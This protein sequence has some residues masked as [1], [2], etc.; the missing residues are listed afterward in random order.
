MK[1]MYCLYSG[2][3]F[4]KSILIWFRNM[5]ICKPHVANA[6]CQRRAVLPPLQVLAKQK[7]GSCVWGP[8]IEGPTQVR[9]ASDWKCEGHGHGCLPGPAESAWKECQRSHRK[10]IIIWQCNVE[11]HARYGTQAAIAHLGERPTKN[12]KGPR[13]DP[14]TRHDLFSPV[15]AGRKNKHIIFLRNARGI[16]SCFWERPQVF[17]IKTMYCI[18]SGFA[19]WKRGSI[20]LRNISICEAH[21]P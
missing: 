6:H 9:R 20:R 13:F 18:Y 16:L 3:A 14:G 15:M 10:N 7:H 2:F 12:L 11:W 21:L 5:S 1:T 19:F 4:W 17:V 8:F